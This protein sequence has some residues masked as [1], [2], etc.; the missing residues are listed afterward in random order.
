MSASCGRAAGASSI[1][2]FTRLSDEQTVVSEPEFGENVQAPDVRAKPL[3]I[4]APR[5]SFDARWPCPSRMLLISARRNYPH[6]SNYRNLRNFL[7]LT[8]ARNP[9]EE[10]MAQNQNQGGQQGGGQQG[11]DQQKPGQQEQ[12]PGQGGQQGGGQGGQ[13]NPGQGGQQGGGQR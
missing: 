4:E 11:G 3:P 12:K 10:N 9:T 13:Q 5:T 7:S 6:W 1:S 2:S 8:Q